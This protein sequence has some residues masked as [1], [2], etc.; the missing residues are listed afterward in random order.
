MDVSARSSARVIMK[1]RSRFHSIKSS[2]VSTSQ[3]LCVFNFHTEPSLRNPITV[4]SITLIC[5]IFLK[6]FCD[7]LVVLVP[8]TAEVITI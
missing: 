8:L 6:Y 4:G 7:V 1:C 5:Y 2:D 3:S